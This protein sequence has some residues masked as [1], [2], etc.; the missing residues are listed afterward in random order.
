M[1]TMAIMMSLSSFAVDWL[2][3]PDACIDGIAY[4]LDRVTKEASVTYNGEQPLNSPDATGGY[5]GVIT[6]P[7]SI[8]HEGVTYKVTTI[9]KFA[10][11]YCKEITS[12]TI[13]NSVTNIEKQAFGFC[14]G[15]TSITIPNSVTKIGAAAFQFCAGITSIIIPNSV[16]S[17][18]GNAF[19]YCE[20]LTSIK[21]PDSVTDMG[22]GVF[23]DCT[24]LSSVTLGSGLKEIPAWTFYACCALKSINIPDNIIYIGDQAFAGC[25]KLKNVE[26]PNTL[27]AIRTSAFENCVSITSLTIPNSV[28]YLGDCA[29]RGCTKLSF[30]SISNK[31]DCINSYTFGDCTELASVIIP[32]SVEKI[33]DGAFGSCPKLSSVIN[34]SRIPQDLFWVLTYNTYG[35][36]HVPVGCKEVYQN[37]AEWNYFNVIIDDA[38]EFAAQMIEGMINAIGTVKNTA[39]CKSKITAARFAFDSLSKEVQ[40]LVK[41][42]NLL[43]EAEKTYEKMSG[44]STGIIDI[45][46]DNNEISKKIIENGKIVIVKNGKKFNI[47]GLKE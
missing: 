19:E 18:E 7:S 5:T 1:L 15:L 20:G 46:S 10:F 39:A 3:P 9:G 43:I 45:N 22:D 34:F 27:K 26:L 33:D 2:S 24:K 25:K 40:A 23:A 14:S 42:V 38:E 12:I 28:T 13:P 47:N 11:R 32:S 37:A 36:L 4:H 6:I 31:L 44:G 21:I 17:I 30:V 8:T 41:N 16:T 35:D 29:F